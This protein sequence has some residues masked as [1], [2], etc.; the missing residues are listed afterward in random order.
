M[1]PD[2]DTCIV[3]TLVTSPISRS[4]NLAACLGVAALLLRFTPLV[5]FG[6]PGFFFTSETL[7][8]RIPQATTG[9]VWSRG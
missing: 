4:M 9:E 1:N 3:P 8:A 2:F 7:P 5:A 6:K